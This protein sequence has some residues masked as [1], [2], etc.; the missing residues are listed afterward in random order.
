VAS[1]NNLNERGIAVGLDPFIMKHP[2]QWDL[3]AGRIQ[4]ASTVE[5]IIGA[6]YYDSNKN[7][8]ACERVMTALGLT[9]I[10]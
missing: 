2:G 7:H 5:A 4:M 6:V 10:E 8:D 1:N 3:A 9:W